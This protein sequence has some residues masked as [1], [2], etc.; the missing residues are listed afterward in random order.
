MCAYVKY[1]FQTLS[2]KEKTHCLKAGHGSISLFC[3]HFQ[4]LCSDTQILSAEYLCSGS[5]MD[6]DGSNCGICWS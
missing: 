5:H 1:G 4:A 2:G 3:R 6:G